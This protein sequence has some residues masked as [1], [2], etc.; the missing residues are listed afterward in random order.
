MGTGLD[1]S[2][3]GTERTAFDELL[4][5]LARL[6]RRLELAVARARVA[7][8]PEAASDR[9]RGLYIAD[10]EVD[11]LLAREPGAG[12][13]HAVPPSD[14]AADSSDEV[15]PRWLDP[16]SRLG[17]LARA[18]QLTTFE[19]DLLLIALAPE[20]DL[21]Y[22][23]LYAFLQ[24]DVTR[25][26]PTLDLA[27]TLLC[28]SPSGRAERRCHVGPDAPLVR[29]RLVR[30]G[31]ASTMG[32]VSALAATLEADEQITQHLLGHETLSR[33]LASF[34]TLEEQQQL[35]EEDM[36]AVLE[37]QTLARLVAL[38]ARAHHAGDTL[39]LS[40]RGPA[41][42]GRR[43]TARSIASAVSAP[44]LTVDPSRLDGRADADSLLRVAL[45]T[46]WLHGAIV[47]VL[48]A[49][50]L[51]PSLRD[52]LREATREH[53][54]V[55]LHCD[56]TAQSA[57][58]AG[59]AFVVPFGIPALARRRA[60]WEHALTRRGTR[61]TAGTLDA[62]SR[63]FRMTPRQIDGAVAQ[64]SIARAWS[65]VDDAPRVGERVGAESALDEDALFAAARA[66]CGL[67]LEALATRVTPRHRWADLI[68]PT[69]ALSQLQEICERVAN[70]EAVVEGWGFGARLTRGGGVNALFSG[71]SGTGKTMAAEVM[72]G[73]LGVDLF[74]VDLAGVV[75]KYI[76]ETEKNLD[77]V[78]A[79]AEHANG[80]VF[81]DEADAL[82]GKRSEV[83]DSHDRYAN[84]EISYLLQ[85][86][87]QFDGVAILATNLRGNLDDAFVR[88]L[89]FAVHFP[90]P[91]APHR[92]RIWR[93]IWP[94]VAPVDPELDL[95]FL[96]RQFTLSG[97]HIKNIA[98]AA[99]FLAAERGGRIEMRDV[100]HATRREY[101]K[102]GKT[103]TAAELGPFAELAMPSDR[104]N[105]STP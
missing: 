31:E 55:I 33:S 2:A 10:S 54:G 48:D 65:A 104:R 68:L 95:A 66:Q 27:L 37:E 36:P 105:G 17:R 100:V 61:A 56:T 34:C 99:A 15:A 47:L 28:D 57:S 77:R 91:D 76:G 97:G 88:R 63:R 60:L 6:D 11:Q 7:F 92:E 82:F 73:A 23:R 59:D 84:I 93:G 3:V 103:L 75:S 43:T 71:P 51:A 16:M 70:R 62:L 52:V 30:L 86:M 20:L 81:F 94:P 22:E 85:K 5:A 25:R 98:L 32:S 78:F 96:A 74:R 39:Q 29:H 72:A 13:F 4:P 79:A 35:R 19:V 1:S 8:G 14:D 46:G 41:G 24:D 53:A 12:A 49:P 58:S 101:Q 50:L 69:D 64:A 45:R 90:F 87:E 9:F 67:E 38:V 18:F 42:S 44:L 83:H 102:L 89:A 80:I 26:R 21:R 40:C